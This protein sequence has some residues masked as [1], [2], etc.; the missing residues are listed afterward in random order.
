MKE[1]KTLSCGVAESSYNK[2]HARGVTQVTSVFIV[3]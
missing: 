1:V 3:H 2:L